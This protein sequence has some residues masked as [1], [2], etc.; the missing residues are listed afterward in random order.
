MSRLLKT[1]TYWVCHIAVASSLAYLLTGNWHAALAIGLL[2]P[3][4]QAVVFY[5]HELVWDR[6]Q[7]RSGLTGAPTTTSDFAPLAAAA[8]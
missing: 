8:S 6:V 5:A 7:L 4:V 1:G 3:S 2:E